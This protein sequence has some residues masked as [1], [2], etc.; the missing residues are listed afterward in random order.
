VFP[1]NSPARRLK[2]GSFEADLRS[3][4]LTKQGRILRLQ[5]QPFRLLAMLLER[6]RQ[7]VTREEV[8]Q[9]LWPHAV[10][11]FDHGL[12]KAISKI[13]DALGDS[14]ESPR[15]VETV[16]RR[17]YRFVADVAVVLDE[18]SPPAP[19]TSGPAADTPS[20]VSPDL[21]GN[22]EG[23]PKRAAHSGQTPHAGQTEPSG[24]D[25]RKFR[26]G[27]FA[28]WT[29]SGAVLVGL[30]ALVAVLSRWQHHAIVPIRSVAVLPLQNL[31]GDPSQ[32]YFAD[33]M[34]DELINQLGQIRPLR[35]I[36]RT[37]MMTY[38]NVHKPLAD[39][40]RELDVQAVVEGSVL[41]VGDQVRITAQLI[42]VPEDE[43]LWAHSYEGSFRD[44]LALQSE[45]S[46]A[47]AGQI[48][49]TVSHQEHSALT[50]AR[51]VNAE[52]Y[53]AYLK[54]RYFWNRRDA[55]GLEKAIAY[56]QR[57]IAVDPDYA[58]AYS[59]L[60]E[61]YVTA[62]HWVYGVLSPQAAFPQAKA[63]AIQ[64]LRLDPTLSDAHTA[65]AWALNQ[66]TWD[67]EGA[68]REFR[69]AIELNPGYANAH[70]SYAYQLML[71]GRS[72]EGIAEMR[73]AEN[74]D[75]LSL[76]IST[77]VADVLLLARR[78]DESMRQTQKALDMDANF[79]MARFQ[80]GQ[81]LVQKRLFEAAIAQFQRAIELSGHS[82]A[83]DAA[84]AHAH[85]SA[86]HT[87]EAKRIIG[88]LEQRQNPDGV[89]DANIAMVYV[90]LGD[91][92]QAMNWLE[93]AYEARFNP[94]ILLRPELDPLRSNP[95]FKALLQR[96]GLGV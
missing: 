23:S 89:V 25:G 90:G 78:F 28:L 84:L 11:D 9:R 3:G 48:L 47:I 73:M 69:R 76:I 22:V 66:Y 46:R 79:A 71:M 4:E 74:L 39:I 12:N 2:F 58:E 32:E 75:P 81:V 21:L 14:A 56:F 8:R 13:R 44:T 1:P 5:E 36:S 20:P 40:A 68:G 34:T 77:D 53:E 17:G 83:F 65:L 52:A 87:A 62:G 54:A 49:T 30:L 88:E 67:W 26:T 43:H 31:S 18:P 93:K 51:V 72:D 96:L 82:S 85:A 27:P 6:P 86:G 95:R 60:A 38:K 19:A 91:A 63:A 35:V 55:Q 29:G 61:A 70:H 92:E 37:S 41:R 57:A 16:A 15:F 42:R 45:V 10:V 50:R 7:V 64:A 80:M 59:G 94:H 33:G 24:A